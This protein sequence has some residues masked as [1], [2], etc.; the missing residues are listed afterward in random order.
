MCSLM[1]KAVSQIDVKLW[2]SVLSPQI[3]HEGDFFGSFYFCWDV[4]WFLVFRLISCLKL[5]QTSLHQWLFRREREKLWE[6]LLTLPIINI[7]RYDFCFGLGKYSVLCIHS[8]M[9][10]ALSLQFMWGQ[11]S[12]MLIGNLLSPFICCDTP[13]IAPK[14]L[15]ISS[16]K[17]S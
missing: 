7:I 14:L 15:T 5:A 3:Q 9:W 1:H 6:L 13:F 16:L 4:Q 17:V 12:K 2:Y 11:P 8:D 10:S